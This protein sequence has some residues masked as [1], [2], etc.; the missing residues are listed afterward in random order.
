MIKNSIVKKVVVSLFAFGLL[1]AVY[2][3]PVK[4][5]GFIPNQQN[6]PA[7]RNPSISEENL[8]WPGWPWLCAILLSGSIV[9]IGFKHAHRTNKD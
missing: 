7:A 3:T 1:A 4:G 8:R 6:Q 2:T 9:L 5:Q